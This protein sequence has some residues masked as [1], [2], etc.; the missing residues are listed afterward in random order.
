MTENDHCIEDCLEA[1]ELCEQAA[2]HCLRR[3]GAHAEAERV[4]ALVLAAA[5]GSFLAELIR[6]ES[7]LTGPTA[8]FLADACR[9]AGAACRT[10]PGDELLASCADACDRCAE[11][12][13]RT[14]GA[15]QRD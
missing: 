7:L 11:C 12:A 4:D 5:V 3:G 14:L 9:R 1:S 15:P 6:A 2:V 10:L 13:P 8:D